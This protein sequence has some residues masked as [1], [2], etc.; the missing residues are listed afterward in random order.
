MMMGLGLAVPWLALALFPRLVLLM[1]KPGPWLSL[2][3]AV[4]AAGLVLT[5]VWLLWLISVVSSAL[6]AALLLAGLV[7]IWGIVSFAPGR[8]VWPSLAGIM[9]A[10]L[11]SSAWLNTLI[12]ALMRPDSP[13]LA[14]L[15]G[16]KIS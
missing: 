5:M 1:P 7:L 14:A 15:V 11:V 2:C 13:T 16:N 8:F 4:L 12:C 3:P 10:A 9:V 6:L